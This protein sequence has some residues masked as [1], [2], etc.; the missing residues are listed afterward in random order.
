MILTALEVNHSLF[1]CTQRKNAAVSW[2][3]ADSGISNDDAPKPA[4]VRR[5]PVEEIESMQPQQ[6]Q[7]EEENGELG[8]PSGRLIKLTTP[9]VY[10]CLCF[11]EICL[12]LV[13]VEPGFVSVNVLLH[14][15][16]QRAIAEHLP[17]QNVPQHL[18]HKVQI[19]RIVIH[20]FVLSA[21]R[22]RKG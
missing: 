11:V 20:G 14:H 18:L 19:N 6:V 7:G 15:F 9:Q 13:G 1:C 22:K 21:K 2:R 16:L 12:H 4:F 5:A 3:Q 8:I 17:R 10:A